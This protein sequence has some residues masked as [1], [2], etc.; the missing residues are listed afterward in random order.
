VGFVLDKEGIPIISLANDSIE[1]RNI[2]TNPRC[3]LKVQPAAYPARAL[4]SVTLMGKLGEPLPSVEGN[5]GPSN[6]AAYPLQVDKC[7]YFGGMDQVQTEVSGEELRAAEPDMLR[8]D[9]DELIK[10]WNDERAEDIYRIV[11]HFMD[12]P[13]I[14]MNYAELLWVDRL[15][16]Y[17]RVEAANHLD[18]LV[19]A[20][21]PFY[22]PVL[23]E[24]DARS[25]I[26]MAAQLA[27]EEERPYTPPVPSIYTDPAAAA[28]N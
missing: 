20:R 2:A 9:L 13:L 12:I 3:S 15:G 4:A 16:M 28:N 24:R 27:W 11:S 22:R 10:T 19:I 7:L 5:Q 26:T 8:N 1:L 23:D 17:V 18:G 6:I 14:E 25:V 21:V